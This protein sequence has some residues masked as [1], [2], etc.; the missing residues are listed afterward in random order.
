MVQTLNPLSDKNDQA[1]ALKPLQDTKDA[2]EA[3]LPKDPKADVA[4]IDADVSTELNFKKFKVEKIDSKTGLNAK[5]VSDGECSVQ[6]IKD[7]TEE[8][9]I[10]DGEYTVEK[11]K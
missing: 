9:I 10:A 1:D 3:A 7:I 6:D 2:A 11:T 4:I 5:C 8:Y